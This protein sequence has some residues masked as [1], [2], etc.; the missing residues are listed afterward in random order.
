MAVEVVNWKTNTNF[1]HRG[2]LTIYFAVFIAFL[3]A[4]I[5]GY[6]NSIFNN[7]ATLNSF[8]NAFTGKPDF[9]SSSDKYALTAAMIQIGEMA[10]CLVVGYISDTFGRR[11]ALMVGSIIVIT[12]V[13]LELA[14]HDLN[15]F[16]FGR[17]VIGFGV[18]QVTTAAPTYTLEVA[19]PQFR[20]WATGIYNTGWGVGSVPASIILLGTYVDTS[21]FAWRLPVGVQALYSGIVLVGCLFIPESPRW[22]MS[23]GREDEARKFLVHYHGNDIEDHPIVELTMSEMREALADEIRQNSGSYM[24]LFKGRPMIYRFWLIIAIAFFSQYAGNWLAGGFTVI[25]NAQFGF[26]TAEQQLGLSIATSALGFIF[27]QIGAAYCERIGRRP[28]I[29]YG[30]LGFIICWTLTLICLAIYNNNT[31][32]TGVGIAGWVI[33]QIFGLIYAFSWNAINALYPVEILPYS[34]RAKGMAMCQ[35]FIN[36]SGV[37][38]SYVLIYGVNTWEWKFDSFY[39][40]FNAFALVIVYFFFPETQGYSLE[41]IVQIFDDPNPVKKSITDVRVN[42][43]ATEIHVEKAKV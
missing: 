11:G 22:L 19:H 23:K 26:K 27:A 13:V 10:G 32:L 5:N 36:L 15:V 39:L 38:Q 24:A 35:F 2:M 34:A 33:E 28:L 30:T 21:D 40:F 20:S 25:T 29:I 41:K 4:A 17:F 16:I 12:G 1:Y 9:Q 37:I 14:T 8:G 6:D 42:V 3:N 31:D 18:S 7:M 43:E